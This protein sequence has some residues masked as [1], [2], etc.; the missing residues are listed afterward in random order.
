MKYILAID[1]GT[2]GPKVALV[3]TQG[4]VIAYE[5]EATPTLL[6]PN[7]GAEQHPEDWWRA[8]KVALARLLDRRLVPLDDLA[9]ISCT[10]QWSGTV[11]IDQNL[12]PLANAIIW[13]D[14]RG[15]PYI[16]RIVAGSLAIQGY[17]LAKLFRWIPLTGGVPTHS[18]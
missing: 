10:T 15:A 8:I 9:A 6:L 2:S 3:T 17:D 7:G 11:V 14:A 12:Q 18:G 5:F 4:E 16:D 13:M 1:L